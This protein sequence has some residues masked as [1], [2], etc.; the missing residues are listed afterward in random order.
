MGGI[1]MKLNWKRGLAAL[2]GAVALMAAPVKGQEIVLTGCSPSCNA[3][4]ACDQGEAAP[5]IDTSAM[6]SNFGSSSGPES[7][8]PHMIGDYISK[9][10]YSSNFSPAG[11]GRSQKF[12]EN[13]SA[14]PTDRAY[15]NYS[16]FRNVGG[17]GSD[18]GRH[19]FGREWLVNGG[20]SSLGFRIPVWTVDPVTG[21][22]FGD[23]GA[24]R[25]AFG[26]LSVIFKHALIN[27]G[28]DV[29]SV[30]TGFNA[31]T[32]PSTFAGAGMGGATTPIRH[33]G[34]IQTFLGGIRQ[35]GRG[36][37][38]QGFLTFDVPIDDTDAVFMFAD[39]QFG[40]VAY[41]G[42]GSGITA[43]IPVFEIH[44]NNPVGQRVLEDTAI[45]PAQYVDVVSTTVGL[46]TV[47]NNRSALTYGLV[48][49]VST[50]QPFDYEFQIQYNLFGGLGLLGR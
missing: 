8:A 6:A 4:A 34:T 43:L 5:D 41:T 21:G 9:L 30:G 1:T 25:G 20:N 24:D 33:D 35:L 48:T 23:A 28:G 29:L 12:A 44:S 31:P 46:T 15:Y 16:F 11:A 49:P 18:L 19:N 40:Y 45:V 39:V 3:P 47:F 17:G 42:S 26:D 38:V 2:C 36:V 14:A 27:D 10:G 37:Y 22:S 7:I 32:G 50:A 13:Q